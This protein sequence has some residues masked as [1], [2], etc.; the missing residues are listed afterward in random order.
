MKDAHVK[1][2]TKLQNRGDGYG[3][4]LYTV[5]PKEAYLVK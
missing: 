5:N 4:M 2:G 3:K 1:N